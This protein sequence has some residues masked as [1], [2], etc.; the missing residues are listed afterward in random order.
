MFA[1]GPDEDE[2]ENMIAQSETAEFEIYQDPTCDLRAAHDAHLTESASVAPSVPVVD[3][4]TPDERRRV[5][6]D[7][8][9]VFP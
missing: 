1:D 6:G 4:F 5:I 9:K 3:P 2:K 7:L 8:S